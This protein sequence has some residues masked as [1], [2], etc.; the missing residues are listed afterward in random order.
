[1]TSRYKFFLTILFVSM[2]FAV[3]LTSNAAGP[4]DEAAGGGDLTTEE[5]SP[6]IV[7]TVPNVLVEFN[8]LPQGP[9][10][11][12]DIQSEFHES[13][14]TGLAFITREGIGT[15]DFQTGGG[16]ALAPNPD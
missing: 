2:L 11:L 15:Y 6:I 8:F 9:T 5:V 10:T 13:C 12:E 4:E 16:R 3:P 14:I 1:M 7:L